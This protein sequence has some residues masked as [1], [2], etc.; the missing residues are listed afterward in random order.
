MPQR[1]KEM[2]AY[3]LKDLLMRPVSDMVAWEV[4]VESWFTLKYGELFITK[5]FP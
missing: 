5:N 4:G 2:Q 3:T 1:Q